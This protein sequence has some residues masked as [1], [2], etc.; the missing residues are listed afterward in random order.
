M[1]AGADVVGVDTSN[2]LLSVARSRGLDARWMDAAALE[3]SDE[4]DAVFSNA[5]LHWVLAPSAVAAGMHAALR[6]GGRLAV[7]F[8]G[9]GNIAAILTG[10]RAVLAAHGYRDLPPDQYY[11]TASEYSTVLA[12]VGFVDIKA[13]LVSRP[14][15]LADGMDA[16]LRTFRQGLLEALGLTPSEQVEVRREVVELLAPSLRDAADNWIADY[17]RIRVTARRS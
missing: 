9:F 1:Q 15:P 4:F 7:E 2:E 14:T 5:A 3:F 11:P 12:G 13:E 6:R 16:W 8:G 17:V 10:L